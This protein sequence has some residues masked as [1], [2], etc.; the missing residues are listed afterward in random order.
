MITCLCCSE[1]SAWKI[2]KLD[3]LHVM[4]THS[5]HTSTFTKDVHGDGREQTS[6]LN[7]PNGDEGTFRSLRRKP[8]VEEQRKD[9]AMEDI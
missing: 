2:A 5:P 9:Q 3:L 8:F 7:A 6:Q 1:I 4:L